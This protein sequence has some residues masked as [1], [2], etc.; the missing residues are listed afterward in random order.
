MSSEDRQEVHFRG[1]ATYPSLSRRTFRT[2]AGGNSAGRLGMSAVVV[3]YQV[4]DGK[5][6]SIALWNELEVEFLKEAG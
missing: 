1:P 5:R 2:G 6:A 3:T 4:A